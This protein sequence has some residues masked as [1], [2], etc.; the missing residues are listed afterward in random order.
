MKNHSLFSI[1]LVAT[2]FVGF[3][4][5]CSKDDEDTNDACSSFPV[6][7]GEMTVNGAKQRL[8][9]AQFIVTSNFYNFQLASV[10]DDCNEQKAINF[11]IQLADGAK[12]NG[13]YPIKDFFSADINNAS[14]SIL[15]QK[16]S[17]ISQSS[18]DLAS[19]TIKI[20]ELG[21]KKYTIDLNAT[22]VLGEKIILSLT[23]QF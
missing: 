14:G 11:S 10:S 20:T 9:I 21:I 17:P 15:S 5:S 18:V 2:L 6:L 23:H 22:D 4:S 7:A 16:V 13:T 1:L 8:S 12:L 3:N 19:G